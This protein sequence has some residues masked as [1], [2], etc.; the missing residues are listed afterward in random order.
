[1]S[2]PSKWR[3]IFLVFKIDLRL[4]EIHFFERVV[5][6]ILGLICEIAISVVSSFGIK[7]AI[8]PSFP[9]FK[10]TIV[11]SSKN[12][13]LEDLA[14]E[15]L[16]CSKSSSK[17]NGMS[18]DFSTIF[19]PKAFEIAWKLLCL[20]LSLAHLSSTSPNLTFDQS[21]FLISENLL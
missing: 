8:F 20:I 17:T 4:W 5:E 2:S 10:I 15:I 13:E 11:F 21:I 7:E 6:I 9:R 16:F 12:N 19:F 3:I 18:D 14:N 1:M